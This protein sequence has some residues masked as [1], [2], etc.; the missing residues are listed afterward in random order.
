MTCYWHEAKDA[1]KHWNMRE[2]S[3]EI[4]H[5]NNLLKLR[6]A[7]IEYWKKISEWHPIEEAPKNGTEVQVCNSTTWPQNAI[8]G[9]LSMILDD[10]EQ[11]ELDE[12]TLF[13]TAWFTVGNVAILDADLAPTHFRYLPDLPECKDEN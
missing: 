5:S 1:A 3:Q 11:E 13:H 4:Q 10:R 6:D 8:Y 7:E 12:K 9:D 2:I